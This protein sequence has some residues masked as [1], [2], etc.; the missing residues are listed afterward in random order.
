MPKKRIPIATRRQVHLRAAGYCEYCRTPEIFSPEPFCVEHIVP[1]KLGGGNTPD[2]LA[3]ACH[4]CNWSKSSKTQGED[5]V[6]RQLVSLFNPRRQIWSEH[7]AWMEEPT[8]VCGLTAT[9]RATV[10]VLKLN[11]ENLIH[12]RLAMYVLGEHPPR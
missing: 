3:L 9:G 11:R 4:G 2:N 12:L 8:H 7:F 1:V 10:E 5:P 6:S